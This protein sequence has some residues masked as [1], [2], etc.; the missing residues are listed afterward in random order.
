MTD[1]LSEAEAQKFFRELRLEG[2]GKLLMEEMC[3]K[4]VLSTGCAF[5]QNLSCLHAS[6]VLPMHCG[7]V[8]K[9]HPSRFAGLQTLPAP[10]RA[11]GRGWPSRPVCCWLERGLLN[12]CE[13]NRSHCFLNR[14]RKVVLRK[15]H[16]SDDREHSGSHRTNRQMTGFVWRM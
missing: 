3:M 14:V 15:E 4:E 13:C 10:R 9:Q 7:V 8:V 2:E 1:K 12:E 16:G 11:R 6:W 5:I